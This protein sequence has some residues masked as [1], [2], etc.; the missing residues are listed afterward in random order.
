MKLSKWIDNP[1][2]YGKTAFSIDDAKQLNGLA[3]V[4]NHFTGIF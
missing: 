2:A 1:L 3:E 4:A